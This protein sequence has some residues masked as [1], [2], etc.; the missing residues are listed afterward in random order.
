MPS[1]ASI[2]TLTHLIGLALAIGAATAK[3]TL[4]LKSKSDPSFVQ[5]FLAASPPLTHLIIGGISLLVISGIG[6]VLYG[7]PVTPLLVT[8]L[9][10]VGAVIAL[11]PVIDKIIEPKFRSLAPATAAAPPSPDF[12][13]IRS[14][15]LWVEVLATGLMFLI[16]FLWVLA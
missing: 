1:L 10:L 13:R 8:K 3:L 9:F 11:G 5:T 15:Y 16:V 2:L 14:R 6:W 7:Y 12:V 4:L